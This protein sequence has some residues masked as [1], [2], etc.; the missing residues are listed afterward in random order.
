[1]DVL[2]PQLDEKA[3]ANNLRYTLHHARRTLA[4]VSDPDTASRLLALRGELIE[5]GAEG[6]L[7][8]DVEAFEEAA[9]TVR[10]SRDVGAY[11][12]AL[13]LYAGELLP[14]DPYEAWAQERREGLR[15]ARLS[16]LLELAGLYERRGEYEAAAEAL[17]KALASE[18]AHEGAHAQLMRVYAL[19]GRRAE[20]LEQYERLREAL[21]RQDDTEPS[22][23]SMDLYEAIRTERFPPAR[24]PRQV[25]G[26]SR[27]EL[28]E[29]QYSRKHNLPA[30]LT[31]FVGR[32]QELLEVKR[33]LAMS[34]LLTLRGAGGSGK[35]RL[36]LEV[37]GDLVG[38]YP[39]GAWFVELAPLVEGGLVQQA[40]AA[41][42]SVKERA[43]RPLSDTL[44]DALR[45]EQMLLVLDNCEHLAEAAARL[46]ET[47]L[48][49]CPG[50]RVLAT[51][52]EVLGARGEASWVVPTLS[53][54]DPQ[55]QQTLEELAGYESVR[56]FVQRARSRNPA[57][58]LSEE[59]AQAVAELCSRLEGIP[60]AIELAAA[61]VGMLSVELISERLADS[62][63]LL[64]SDRR[65]VTRRQRTLR[66][67]LDWSHELLSEPE[68]VLFRR[69]SPFAGGWTVEA[70]EAV[71]TD[72]AV[73]EGKVPA[74]LSRLVERSLVTTQ[75]TGEGGVRFGMLEPVRQYA[76]ER[77]EEH[78]E[79]A[80]IRQRHAEFFLALAEE[81]EPELLGARQVAWL[82]RLEREHGN[83]RV[84]LRWLLDEKEAEL[85][86]RMAGVLWLFWFTRGHSLEGW[87]WLEEAISL[88]GPPAARAKALNGGGYIALFQGNYEA[89]KT[90]LEE[91]LALYRQL[92]QEEGIASS[93]TYLGSLALLGQREDIPVASLLEEA[94][95]LRPRLKNRHTIANILVFAG[96]EA[97]H[98]RGDWDEAVALHEEALALYREMGDKRGI[99]ICLIDL[100]LMLVA[101]EQHTR[102]TVLLRELMQVSRELDD[103]LTS[104]YSFFGL[105]CVAD[106]EGHAARAARLW[107]VSEA[108]RE[109]A[110]IRLTS[111]ALS[112]MRYESRLTE[113]RARLGEATFEEAWEEGKAMTIEEAIEYALSEEESASSSVLT[114]ERAQAAEPMGNLTRREQ[115]V[116]I[117][118]ARGLTNRQI[119][120]KL[121]ISERTA[122]NHVA[123]I[124]RKLGLRSR[125]QIA[126]WTTER[127][128]LA[129]DPE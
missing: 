26:A 93:L 20:A 118:I 109:A 37:A 61:R 5:L 73:E 60:L 52:R 84:A 18:P 53:G 23:Q 36:A 48:E 51:S 1:M 21:R 129:P 107:G 98:L 100:G 77:L 108:I 34:R 44:V 71:G 121:G 28:Y 69:L 80:A 120:A 75:A 101:L 83:L 29:E 72:G 46:T 88:G 54:P 66:G 90:L 17:Q 11:R 70:A 3:Q 43:D 49:S 10:G 24:L 99:T 67:A 96:L 116:A 95:M 123:R 97:L 31:S 74:L 81:A 125:A 13:D 16:L 58:V 45:N 40:V 32:E 106:S 62:L 4:L 6:S 102:G 30:S 127:Q 103:K 9:R 14:H 126:S 41:A 76:Q 22:A 111:L 82:G 35:T 124:L 50:L 78:G 42:L 122:G 19:S 27:E 65:T 128:L 39:G 85:A 94:M 55:R 112:V 114:P 119:S 79:D 68:R 57:F 105:A 56:L 113:A 8:V 64:R 12:A 117:H 33:E 59:N 15:R 38:A 47:L 110:G 104:Q 25:E 92:K 86:L 7:S 89:A 115:E 63:E 2:W 91:S 87:R